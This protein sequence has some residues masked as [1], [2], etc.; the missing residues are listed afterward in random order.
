MKNNHNRLKYLLAATMITAMIAMLVWTFS[1]ISV[2]A[3]SG[4][5]DRLQAENDQL[6]Q[7]ISQMQNREGTFRTQIQKANETIFQLIEQPEPS[8]PTLSS[9]QTE[10]QTLQEKVTSLEQQIETLQAPV[11][12]AF[13]FGS[14]SE[15]EEHDDD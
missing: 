15:H 12:S 5:L 10:N 7:T 3:D 14:R 9:L 1:S 8:V 13:S 2:S 11:Q 6:R 4:S